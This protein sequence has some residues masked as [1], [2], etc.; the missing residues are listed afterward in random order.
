MLVSKGLTSVLGGNNLGLDLVPALVWGRCRVQI[1][2]E[3]DTY[4]SA[5]VTIPGLVAGSPSAG[6]GSVGLSAC[7]RLVGPGRCGGSAGSPAPDAS[8]CVEGAALRPG[9]PC[10][11]GNTRLRV[12]CISRVRAP[13]RIPSAGGTRPGQLSQ[14]AWEFFVEFSEAKK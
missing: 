6:F 11:C 3:C 2:V 10:T 14:C 8:V 1:E 12:A 13:S 4:L 7:E 9:M 5:A